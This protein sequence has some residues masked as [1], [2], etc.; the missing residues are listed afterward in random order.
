MAGRPQEEI[1]EHRIASLIA[2]AGPG[3]W[4]WSP[5]T[6][7]FVANARLRRIF[8]FEPNTPLSFEILL[9]AT[10]PQDRGWATEIGVA[11]GFSAEPK[12]VQFRILRV[13]TGE[14]RWVAARLWMRKELDR[15]PGHSATVEDVTDQMRT[16]VA[17]KESEQRLRLAIEAGKMAVWEIDLD[18]QTMTQSVEL[19][20]LLGFPPGEYVTLA[21]V[22]ALYNPGEME[23]IHRE[24]NS[25]EAIRLRAESGG[26]K[27]PHGRGRGTSDRTQVQAEVAITTPAGVPKHLMLRCQYAPFPDGRPRLTGLLID[28]SEAKLAQEKLTTVAR[29]LNHRVKNSISVV[30]ALAAKT[31]RGHT[32]EETLN[33]YLERLEALAAA[34]DLILERDMSNAQVHTIIERILNPYRSHASDPFVID[35][36]PTQLRPQVAL[37]SAMILHELCTNAVK[38][39]ALSQPE[40]RIHIR[41]HESDDQLSLTWEEKNGPVVEPPK[42]QGFGTRLLENLLAKEGGAVRLDFQKS[43][44]SCTITLPIGG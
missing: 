23:R 36:P 21:Q 15:I 2:H 25:A 4:D 44:L 14:Q 30:H 11:S 20:D 39:G 10:H 28:I 8:G 12:A 37:A 13:D 5:S 43:G 32:N 1:A 33:T 41:W 24:G 34:N 18:A 6:R 31:L 3:A 42:R 17:L 22:R 27:I 16:A 38:Y 19:N 29:E 9:N 7:V 40:G 35:G 26:L